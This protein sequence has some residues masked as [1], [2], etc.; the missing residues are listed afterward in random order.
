MITITTIIVCFFS[1]LSCSLSNLRAV[2]FGHSSQKLHCYI[3]TNLLH[4]EFLQV[5]GVG[6][7]VLRSMN[8]PS[9]NNNTSPTL[10]SAVAMLV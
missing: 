7:K 2:L 5:V 1:S 6:A 3:I 8:R 10:N 9:S 4:Q